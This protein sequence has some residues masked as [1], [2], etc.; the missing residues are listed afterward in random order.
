MKIL[1]ATDGSIHSE[2]AVEAATKFSFQPGS[3]IKIITVTE[4]ILPVNLDIYGSGIVSSTIELE[5]IAGESSESVL[6]KARKTLEERFSGENIFITT[7]ILSGSPESRIVEAAEKINADLIIVG[8]HGYNTW[9]RLLLGS[10]SDSVAHHAPCS[11]LVVR[12]SKE[13]NSV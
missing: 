10:V 12:R 11:V 6:E 13:E 1:I 9:E 5:K 8:S 4:T 2:K 3:E 7:E